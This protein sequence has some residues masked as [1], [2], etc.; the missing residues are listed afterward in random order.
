MLF[1]ETFSA[2]FLANLFLGT[3]LLCHLVLLTEEKTARLSDG[4]A[5]LIRKK[6]I[7]LVKQI[8]VEFDNCCFQTLENANRLDH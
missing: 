1:I 8:H 3:K 4:V 2:S 7:S 5:L 6:N